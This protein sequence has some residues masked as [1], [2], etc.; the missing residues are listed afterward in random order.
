MAA[1]AHVRA[2]LDPDSKPPKNTLQRFA[3]CIHQGYKWSKTPE[4]LVCWA[5][6]DDVTNH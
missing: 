4:A 3:N 2:G 1:D 6:T 5:C